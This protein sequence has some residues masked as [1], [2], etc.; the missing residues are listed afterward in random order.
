M[1]CSKKFKF[2]DEMPKPILAKPNEL[3]ATANLKDYDFSK[4]P[5]SAGVVIDYIFT[6]LPGLK[7][8]VLILKSGT[9]TGKST[10]L[11]SETYLKL[12]ASG[13]SGNIIAT[14]PAVANPPS[15]VDG[16]IE[17]GNGNFTLGEN[18]GYITGGPKVP[19]KGGIKV[20]TNAIL[21]LELINNEP[22]VIAKRYDAIFIDEVHKSSTELEQ[23]LFLLK[24]ASFAEGFPPIVLMSGTLDEVNLTQF[25]KCDPVANYI[26]VK[27]GF[28]FDMTVTYPDYP[29]RDYDVDVLKT[30]E[31]I[32]K[33][34][35]TK[36]DK[37]L[38]GNPTKKPKGELPP[39]SLYKPY[40]RYGIKDALIF[41]N[42]AMSIDNIAEAVEKK[43]PGKILVVKIM[44]NTLR[45][46]GRDYENLQRVLT[47]ADAPLEM[48]LI[49]ATNAVET[50]ITID[51]LVYLIDSGMTKE[52]AFNPIYGSS[53]LID[54]PID[55]FSK[56][57]RQGRVA[58]AMDGCFLPL[59]PERVA[60]AF[61][62]ESYSKLV[63]EDCSRFLLSLIASG[64]AKGGFQDF[65]FMD[66]RQKIPLQN[67][68][69]A[70]K[71]LF[72]YGLIDSNLTITR[73]GKM[74]NETPR[75]S[76]H[77]GTFVFHM[78]TYTDCHL[79]DIFAMAAFMENPRSAIGLTKIGY[80]KGDFDF[81]GM[82]KT[83]SKEIG[84]PMF[85][86]LCGLA[87]VED[88]WVEDLFENSN[89]LATVLKDV[90]M[91]RKGYG[92]LLAL[93][94][95]LRDYFY[96][97]GITGNKESSMGVGSRGGKRTRFRT[98]TASQCVAYFAQVN[99]VI[100]SLGTRSEFVY[101]S[102]KE[103]WV[104]PSNTMEY[105]IPQ[106]ATE[107][108]SRVYLPTYLI[109]GNPR[110]KKYDIV[111]DFVVKV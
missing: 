18:I 15:I 110:S 107:G 84:N 21:M 1:C 59:Y 14:Q 109:M 13:K 99:R 69:N 33:D 103:K 30:I 10:Y 31:Y 86:Y 105:Y 108:I 79:D 73:F 26:E 75:V 49:I 65:V 81:V 90:R 83:Y 80:D 89:I 28:S 64:F 5:D 16:I 72:H 44:G 20:V 95:T 12:V 106:Q 85:D 91:D 76:T 94:A 22:S 11:L 67:I 35:T 66:L 41:V 74:L 17:H 9:G 97:L 68:T 46:R 47:P 53:T 104:C 42:S 56:A 87:T 101:D 48:K 25:F 50:G 92:N 23:L 45:D 43:W 100:T 8:N 24:K 34:G 62:K 71:T 29:I 2:C 3:V 4:Y 37:R 39:A 19:T 98:L 57:Q 63:V 6:K 61:V 36:E 78:I 88:L 60:N 27:G 32:F 51:G 40:L 7:R 38:L 96:K 77:V 55:A 54:K 93:I 52:V 82:K 102:K 111:T 70:L 58:R